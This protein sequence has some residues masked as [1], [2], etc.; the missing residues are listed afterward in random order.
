MKN[1]CYKVNNKKKSFCSNKNFKKINYNINN[2][3]NNYK[4]YNKHCYNN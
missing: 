3:N 2:D 4:I 1:S